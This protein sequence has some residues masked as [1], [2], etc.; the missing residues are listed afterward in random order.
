MHGGDP[1]YQSSYHGTLTR[2]AVPYPPYYYTE[3]NG[4]I[5]SPGTL[6][7]DKGGVVVEKY[8]PKFGP[9]MMIFII[10]FILFV[11][12][13]IILLIIFFTWGST[14][15]GDSRVYDRGGYQ[16]DL[17]LARSIAI[18]MNNKVNYCILDVAFLAPNYQQLYNEEHLPGARHFDIGKV[19]KL[20]SDGSQVP[21]TPIEFQSY[22]R[23]LGVNRDC[24][25][26]IYDHGETTES[27]IAAT[28]AWFLFKLYNH[29]RVTVINGGLRAWRSLE[30]EFPQYKATRDAPNGKSGDFVAGWNAKLWHAFDDLKNSLERGSN[31]PTVIDTRDAD[32]YLGAKKDEK[33]KEGGRIRGALNAP[34]REM[35]APGDFG[36][37]ILPDLKSWMASRGFAPQGPN[38]VYSNDGL[39]ASLLYFVMVQ[40]GWEAQLYPSGWLEWS[41]KA[42]PQLKQRG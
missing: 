6:Q 16:V 29:N 9:W 7:Y 20:Q 38:V 1:N 28:F 30:K 42:P 22:A 33:A 37:K 23:S 24:Y 27:M 21:M 3:R 2:N 4:Y 11:L 19:V 13:I 12:A 25:V 41:F 35:L 34:V 5:S 32:F 18:G 31:A 40:A 17:E 39:H 15:I 36:L 10:L 8:R 14:F 26:I